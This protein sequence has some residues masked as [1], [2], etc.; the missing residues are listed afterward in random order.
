[1][2][3]VFTL[4]ESSEIVDTNFCPEGDLGNCFLRGGGIEK[5]VVKGG[6]KWERINVYSSKNVK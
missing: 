5:G 3:L 1:M 4:K 6:M 2:V